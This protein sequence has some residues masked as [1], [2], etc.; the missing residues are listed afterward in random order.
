MP[1]P[2]TAESPSVAPLAAIM[3]MNE[4]FFH[5]LQTFLFLNIIFIIKQ[6]KK[7]SSPSP[8]TFFY[9]SVYS[10]GYE[11]QRFHG[12]TR[13]YYKTGKKKEKRRK[14]KRLSAVISTLLG[15]PV[16]AKSRCT[17]FSYQRNNNRIKS[18]NQASRG[19]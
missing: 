12:A 14:K 1:L 2:L 13:H 18:P 19:V 11:L 5:F 8:S 15:E 10:V 4:T 3:Q 17:T 9:I 6:A 7:T 16:P